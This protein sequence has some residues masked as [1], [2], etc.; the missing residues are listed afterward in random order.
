MEKRQEVLNQYSEV[1]KEYFGTRRETERGLR[2]PNLEIT[3]SD[4]DLNQIALRDLS[5]D[6]IDGILAATEATIRLLSIEEE[7]YS[8]MRQKNKID[9]ERVRNARLIGGAEMLELAA[10]LEKA[11]ERLEESLEPAE[12]LVGKELAEEIALVRD[13]EQVQYENGRIGSAAKSSSVKTDSS[14][15]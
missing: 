12:E 1:L 10:N 14:G 8:Q 9:R 11:V 6:E 15:E 2:G 5:A 4:S 3:I 7:I 13:I